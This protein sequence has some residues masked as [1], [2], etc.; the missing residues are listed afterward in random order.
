[1]H[2]SDSEC[3]EWQVHVYTFEDSQAF[4]LSP[5]INT[6]YVWCT[7]VSKTNSTS[8]IYTLALLHIRAYVY[9]LVF[10]IRALLESSSPA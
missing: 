8:F 10:R 6:C 2:G 4:R 1:M 9:H 5:S 3:P 7:H